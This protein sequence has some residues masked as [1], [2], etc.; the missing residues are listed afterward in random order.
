MT[1]TTVARCSGILCS[2]MNKKWF[3]IGAVAGAALV[4]INPFG[5][6]DR[7]RGLLGV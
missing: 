6:V 5:V 1:V 4:I 2:V 3:I 7:V